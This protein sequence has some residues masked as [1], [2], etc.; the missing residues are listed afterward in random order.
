M[1][2]TSWTDK[3]IKNTDTGF[4]DSAIILETEVGNFRISV[5]Y[6]G[7]QVHSPSGTLLV[8][9]ASANTFRVRINERM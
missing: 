1:K 9:L 8:E 3:Y 5:E 4:E 2:V 7:L 6:D